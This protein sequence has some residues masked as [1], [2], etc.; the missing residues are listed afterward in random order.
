MAHRRT[1]PIA[2]ALAAAT[3]AVAGLPAV[4]AED[5]P[6]EIRIAYQAIPN[7]DL[8][9]KHEGWLEEALPDTKISWIKFDSGGDVNTAFLAGAIDIGLA[10]SSPVT[11]GLSEPNNIPY[12]VAWIHDVI[13]PAESLVARTDTGITDIAGLAG[14][15][16]GTPFASTAHY[17]LLAALYEGGL[18][19]ADVTL[20]DLQPQDILAAWQRGDIQATYVWSPTLDLLKGD[21]TVLADSAE[22]AAKGYPT[23]DLA[24]VTNDFAATYP[25][26]VQEWLRQQDRAV[27]LIQT[28]PA[29]AAVPIAAELSITPEEVQTQLDGLVFVGAADQ[30]SETYLG[31]PDQTGDLATGLLKAAEFLK[32]Q[33]SIDAVPSFETIA[34]GIDTTNLHDAFAGG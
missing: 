15:K 32:S 6:A 26:A 7:G 27:E 21:G 33:G 24:V 5:A 28:D 3:L 1:L 16:I 19:E 12:K 8:I 25:A 2:G 30:R 23:F 29:A 34:V 4:A 13:G 14:Q 22:L 9:V 10:G 17:S 18:T 31:T 20:I 11:R